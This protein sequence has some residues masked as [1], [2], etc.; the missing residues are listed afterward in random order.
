MPTS[1]TLVATS[2][3]LPAYERC[4]ASPLRAEGICPCSGATSK[5]RFAPRQAHSSPAARLSFSDSGPAGGRRG[6]AAR[7]RSRG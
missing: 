6:L 2:V 7:R 3:G 4:I 1:I 5:A